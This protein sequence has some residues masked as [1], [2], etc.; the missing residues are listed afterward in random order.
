MSGRAGQSRL[1]R[2]T[3]SG[4]FEI[5]LVEDNPGDVE[6]TR[7]GLASSS[8][9]HVLHVVEDG[10]EAMRFLRREGT[11]KGKPRPDL[12]VLDLNLPRKDGREVLREIKNDTCLNPIPV[13]ILTSS[14]SYSDALNSYESHANCYVSKPIKLSD[15]LL[16]IRSIV[17][18]WS[19]SVTLP[20]REAPDGQVTAAGSA[21]QR[22][23]STAF[24][25]QPSS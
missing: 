17:E 18:F 16:A 13:V 24:L 7:E 1:G 10:E 20:C 25:N 3:L 19:R 9:G 15:Y 5:L 6:L 14:Q 12:I 11:H 21:K 22:L 8:V 4:L 23:D 2:K